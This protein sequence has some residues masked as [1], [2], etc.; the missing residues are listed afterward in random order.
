MRRG[1][2]R[3]GTAAAAR[4]G[5]GSTW[6]PAA[7]SSAPSPCG[8]SPMQAMPAATAAMVPGTL[9]STTTQAAGRHAL[10]RG[11]GQEHVGR[12]LAAARRHRRCASGPA[13]SAASPVRANFTCH[14][15][16]AG[17]GGDA[18]RQA[19]RRRGARAPRPRP[20]SASTSLASTSIEAAAQMLDPALR[21]LAGPDAPRPRRRC[22]R[23]V[24]DEAL[25]ALR[26][27]HR[28]A[29]RGDLLGDR[30]VRRALAVHQHAVAVEDDQ[31]ERQGG[32]EAHAASASSAALLRLRGVRAVAV[33][34]GAGAAAGEAAQAGSLRQRCLDELGQGGDEAG[35][36]VLR[37]RP[38]IAGD[39]RLLGQL[40]VFDVELDQ[41]L[42]ML[43]DEGD[44][45]DEHGDLVVRRRARSPPRCW[46]RSS[47]CGVARDW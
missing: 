39:A 14:L 7:R 6:A 18:D 36:A 40:A 13:T 16:M 15:A 27:G 5:R 46:G 19:Q 22:R 33:R 26:L 35:V 2:W 44:R 41:R 4:A 20:A 31:A 32:G 17:V 45:H 28:P 23:A 9:S 25:R 21:H 37:R 8:A 24:A 43:G 11:G 42:R 30:P 34:R 38:E 29:E 10:G 3:R 1:A 12:R 47:F